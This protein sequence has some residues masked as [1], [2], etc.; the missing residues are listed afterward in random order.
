MPRACSSHNLVN[1][2]ISIRPKASN[3]PTY[4]FLLQA[5]EMI[6]FPRDLEKISSFIHFEKYHILRTMFTVCALLRNTINEG[7]GCT[8]NKPTITKSSY[9]Q[10]SIIRH[11]LVGNEIVDNSDVAG[12]LPVSLD[13]TP[14]LNGL[15]KD[16]G[17]TRREIF[18][19]CDFM[20]LSKQKYSRQ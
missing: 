5:M 6:I 8:M 1:G 15:G 2:E 11:I 9:H 14:G 7:T 4:W 20:Q 13:L 10:T 18:M 16:N 19:C 17:K 12:A 3:S